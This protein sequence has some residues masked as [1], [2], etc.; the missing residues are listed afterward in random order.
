MK[1]Q[2]PGKT[3][4]AHLT[5]LL[6]L[7]AKMVSWLVR[8]CSTRFLRAA[9][10]LGA[11]LFAGGIQST[12]AQA[13]VLADLIKNADDA[14]KE[15]RW[16]D[17]VT[18]TTGIL[19][20]VSKPGTLATNKKNLAAYAHFRRANAYENL[21]R[22]TEALKNYRK[23]SRGDLYYNDAQKR[24]KALTVTPP[25]P[26]ATPTP[27]PTPQLPLPAERSGLSAPLPMD[28]VPV[29][30]PPTFDENAWLK[31]VRVATPDAAT[32]TVAHG[33]GVTVMCASPAGDRIAS[34]SW[35]D[36]K[37]GALGEVKV[38]DVSGNGGKVELLP[39]WTGAS[40][41]SA[42]WNGKG[43]PPS[44][45]GH[46]GRVTTLSFSPGGALLASGGIGGGVVL[47]DARAGGVLRVL[48]DESRKNNDIAR[49]P[50]VALGWNRSE[51]NATAT[52]WALDADGTLLGWRRRDA[53]FSP[54]PPQKLSTTGVGG[55]AWARVAAMSPAGDAVAVGDKGG[56]VG[57]YETATGRRILD[58]NNSRYQQPNSSGVEVTSLG[59][60]RDGDR[61]FSANFA[62][63]YLNSARSSTSLLSLGAGNRLTALNER[64]GALLS[65]PDGALLAR[66][67]K[68]FVLLSPVASNGTSVVG[69]VA[70]ADV[71]ASKVP[72]LF[73]LL[74]RFNALVEAVPATDATTGSRWNVLSASSP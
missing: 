48:R 70:S 8:G 14:D 29:S 45:G 44:F 21:G 19:D 71:T 33:N 20:D 73:L 18:F 4:E 25:S 40:A 30:T 1:Y 68:R 11:I 67:S 28:G 34:G 60:S 37:G 5:Y 41:W 35:A 61:L 69:D 54:L 17:V 38:W 58:W 16:N 24:I 65:L 55:Q 9:I 51:D 56:F 66:T 49:A 39:M 43:E 72:S 10:I 22:T 50:I 15:K 36:S 13:D 63:I 6:L 42:P 59:F 12:W 53:D 26:K 57:V 32:R 74:P 64:V 23:I 7:I 62:H 3:I 52:L 27:S 46:F 31:N 47:W 2:H